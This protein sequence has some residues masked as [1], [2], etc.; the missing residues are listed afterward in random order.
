MPL[1]VGFMLMLFIVGWED[2]TA[3]AIDAY[4]VL[5]EHFA[6]WTLPRCL[7]WALSA[8]F[9]CFCCSPLVSMAFLLQGEVLPFYAGLSL[10]WWQGCVLALMWHVCILVL[11]ARIAECRLLDDDQLQVSVMEGFPETVRLASRTRRKID[12]AGGRL[13]LGSFYG[14]LLAP[15]LVKDVIAAAVL[16]P[17]PVQLLAWRM[18]SSAF[19]CGSLAFFGHRARVLADRL[20]H[21]TSQEGV[22]GFLH[23]GLG[24]PTGGE[25]LF[26]II[27][28]ATLAFG[29]ARAH[30]EL[31]KQGILEEDAPIR[32]IE[33]L[34]SASQQALREATLPQ[35][36]TAQAWTPLCS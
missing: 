33:K 19:F 30:Q 4:W 5:H 25:E 12:E 6:K 7:I 18:P 31:Q 29:G 15:A 26:C 9:I 36:R 11:L 27:L 10:G 35:S 1:A 28:M 32:T 34:G 20:Q 8:L 21:E 17:D 13:E 14:F 22:R 24:L 16:R 23:A 3:L 2:A